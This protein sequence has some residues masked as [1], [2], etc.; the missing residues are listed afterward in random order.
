MV[1]CQYFLRG[2]CRYGKECRNEHPVDQQRQGGFGNQSWTASSSNTTN[3]NASKPVV[4]FTLDT[5]T[6]DLTPQQDKPL[7]P[8]SSYGAAKYEPIIVG[9]LDES[10]EEL[11]FKAFSAVKDGTIN[12]YMKYETERTAA[13]D[14]TYANALANVQQLYDQ[15]VKQS[16]N[17][18]APIPSVF[19][20]TS[21]STPFNA[22]ASSFGNG[23]GSVFGSGST[24][25]FGK[26]A[27]GQPA[28]GQTAFGSSAPSISVFGQ[29]SQPTS[30]FGQPT[31][32]TS[33]FGQSTPSS[34][35]FG[36]LPQSSAQTASAFG[37]PSQA[38]SAFG[39]PSQTPSAFGQPSQH[40]SAFG[41]PVASVSGFGQP[42]QST[43]GQS[44][45][46]KPASGAFGSTP[47]AGAFA[48][49]AS[50]NPSALGGG[51][52]S[53]FA[54]QPSGLASAA[55]AVNN[56]AQPMSAPSTNGGSVFGQPAFGQSAFGS[57]AISP[58]APVSAVM[59]T[60]PS[61][62]FDS[63]APSAFGTSAP[64]SAFGAPASGSAFGSGPVSAFTASNSP[65]SAFGNPAQ[66]NSI[67]AS[68]K[69]SNSTPDFALAKT[70]FRARPDADRYLALLPTNYADIIPADAKA[71][72][73]SEKFEWGKIPEWVP[74]KEVR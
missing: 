26:P 57:Q 3:A 16:P 18:Q 5:V 30:V 36:Q 62:A 17:N 31:Q 19:G 50:S 1:V 7:W 12:D 27:F 58:V 23:G 38:P 65:V 46:I 24:S 41:Q 59:E 60:A 52:F 43:F 55:A 49:A 2:Q 13:A 45:L 29:S 40:T 32:S 4:P 15:A 61:S 11:R 37:Q 34:S 69:P 8:L 9:S 54:S 14:Q 25:A 42:P 48:S 72:F 35:P 10:F 63:G 22:P 68:S 70:R 64:V 39:Q 47:T 67:P 51:A 74:P 20:S 71:A 28:F 44:S 21:S 73:Q 6:K 56:N 33:A 66:S 53:A